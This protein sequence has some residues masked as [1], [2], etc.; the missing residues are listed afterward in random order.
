MC[1]S[2]EASF[3]VAAACA[4]AG[5]FAVVKC[6]APRYLLLACLPL[7][8]ALQ[9]AA[10]GVVWLQIG[11]SQTGAIVGLFPAV[12]VFY[13]TVFWPTY[14]PLA[15]RAESHGPERR[16][17]LD[18]LIGIGLIISFAFLLKLVGA[19]TF[20]HAENHHVRYTAQAH[21]LRHGLVYKPIITERDWILVP[22]VGVTMLSLFLSTLRPVRLF[23]ALVM[24]ALIGVLLLDRPTL[25]S[26][27]CFFAAAGSVL[28]TFAILQASR[29]TPAGGVSAP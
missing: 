16:R 3:T 2:A 18:V 27:W 12:F 28:I 29:D 26:M 24:F 20:A 19:D 9:Q 25:V 4:G 11:Q 6:P 17:T 15:I 1:F 5:V 21:E 13:A 10:E 23:G 22:Y 14:V 7:S 8:F